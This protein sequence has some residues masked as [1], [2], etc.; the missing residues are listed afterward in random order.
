MGLY[1]KN[2]CLFLLNFQCCCH[3]CL[4][5]CPQWD[6]SIAKRAKSGHVTPS[7]ETWLLAI[8]FP[9]TIL[10][11]PPILPHCT[12][13]WLPEEPPLQIALC[14]QITA[15]YDIFRAATEIF[16]R[17]GALRH[18]SRNLWSTHNKVKQDVEIREWT[19]SDCIDM[20]TLKSLYSETAIFVT[21]EISNFQ[22]VTE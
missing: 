20:T 6:I 7:F 8:L 19:R 18:N 14:Q 16:P 22:V 4:V 10:A 15:K 5:F 17:S 9:P 2:I 13:L 3:W 21:A 11:I 1:V 12:L